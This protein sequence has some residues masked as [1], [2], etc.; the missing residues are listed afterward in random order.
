MSCRVMITASR[1]GKHPDLITLITHSPRQIVKYDAGSVTTT[2]IR[3]ARLETDG[4]PY[5]ENNAKRLLKTTLR[6]QIV[7][8]GARTG[9]FTGRK[10]GIHPFVSTGTCAPFSILFACE[11]QRTY[12]ATSSSGQAFFA[13]CSQLHTI[14]GFIGRLGNTQSL[15]KKVK[16]EITDDEGTTYSLSLH[17]RFSQEKVMRILEMIDLLGKSDHKAPILPAESTSYGRVLKLIQSSYPSKEFSSAD[18]AR[19]YEDLHSASIPLSTVSTYLSRLVDRGVLA[20]QKFG[21][22]WV[23]RVT[24]L[25]KSQLDT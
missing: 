5:C 13:A 6:E 12:L 21:N 15:R 4:S 24:Y 7:E 19:D 23:Y 8:F 11:A 10:P 9:R 18:I 16:V 17:G 22:S 2:L 1:L 20:R 3:E 14:F 25:P